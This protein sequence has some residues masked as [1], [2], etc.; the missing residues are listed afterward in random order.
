[1]SCFAFLDASQAA[2]E[3]RNFCAQKYTGR[4]IYEVVKMLPSLKFLLLYASSLSLHISVRLSSIHLTALV[5]QRP[6]MNWSEVIPLSRMIE[7]KCPGLSLS[8][9][10]SLDSLSSLIMISK[11]ES[12]LIKYFC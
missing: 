12:S 8:L 11:L 9:S 5:G 6:R 7:L 4:R 2:V 3:A 10:L 1:M